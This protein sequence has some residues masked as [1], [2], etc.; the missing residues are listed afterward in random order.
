MKKV[1]GRSSPR[2]SG[3]VLQT[4]ISKIPDLAKIFYLKW[5]RIFTQFGHH[6]FDGCHWIAAVWVWGGDL[7]NIGELLSL[8]LRN[9]IYESFVFDLYAVMSL[10][11]RD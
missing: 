6:I 10:P 8:R 4:S 5:P 2:L 1:A 11:I 3:P 9:P 7:R